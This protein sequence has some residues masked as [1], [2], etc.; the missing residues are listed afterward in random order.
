MKRFKIILEG[1]GYFLMLSDKKE[2]V[3]F[4]T[5]FFVTAKCLDDVRSIIAE[6]LKV[7][8]IENNIGVTNNLLFTSYSTVE[9]IYLLEESDPVE[10]VDGF[11]LYGVSFLRRVMSYAALIYFKVF[12]QGSLILV[13]PAKTDSVNF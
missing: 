2:A 6:K 10:V 1:H 3:G 9:A 11:S 7:R 12:S 8:L 13:D 5:T 4:F